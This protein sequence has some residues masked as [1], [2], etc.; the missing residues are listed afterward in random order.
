[1]TTE[2]TAPA[3]ALGSRSH[4]PSDAP[5]TCAIAVN[6]AKVLGHDP[7]RLGRSR[8]P[9]A[10]GSQSPRAARIETEAS[11]AAPFALA[12]S[13]RRTALLE[14]EPAVNVELKSQPMQPMSVDLDDRLFDASSFPLVRLRRRAVK[15]GYAFAWSAQMRRLL[16][17]A[18]PF[19]IVAEH[20]I[21]ETDDDM[22]LRAAWLRTHR[23]QLAGIAAA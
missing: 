16:K 19:V 4:A 1:M 3:N 2:S 13:D 7:S 20:A 17:L 12:E 21:E 23:V 14:P 5:Q 11:G 22:N 8:C 18:T 15:P 9:R 6:A 10:E